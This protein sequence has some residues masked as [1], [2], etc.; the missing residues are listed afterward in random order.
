MY[1]N[2]QNKGN[3]KRFLKLN[4]KSSIKIVANASLPINK[5]EIWDNKEM[6]SIDVM[7]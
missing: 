4:S 7:R 6:H 5:I 1:I 2:G 3:Q